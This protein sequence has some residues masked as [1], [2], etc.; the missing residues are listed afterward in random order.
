MAPDVAIKGDPRLVGVL[1]SPLGLRER[2]LPYASRA[3]FCIFHQEGL[4]DPSLVCPN[5]C[6]PS[7]RCSI[8]RSLRQ[9]PSSHR[10]RVISTPWPSAAVFA[11]DQLEPFPRSSCLICNSACRRMSDSLA[12][13][14]SLLMPVISASYLRQR[15][16]PY[17]NRRESMPAPF[18]TSIVIVRLSIHRRLPSECRLQPRA[19]FAIH[20]ILAQ[21]RV[22]L[23][24]AADVLPVSPLANTSIC[25]FRPGSSLGLSH[26]DVS[27]HR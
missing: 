9:R 10:K 4:A 1:Q 6:L 21:L 16:S 3:R 18:P 13:R 11:E 8:R 20:A 22:P 26:S 7:I 5:R 17:R 2:A 14:W 19:A 27:S 23:L 24:L 15:P 25:F 12:I